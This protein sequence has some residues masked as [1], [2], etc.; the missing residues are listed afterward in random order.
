[1]STPA[2]RLDAA[3][4]DWLAQKGGSVTVRASPRHGCCGGTAHLP[5]AE[6]GAPA[7]PAGWSRREIDGIAVYVDPALT[8]M[9]GVLTIRLEGIARWRRLFVE[10]ATAGEGP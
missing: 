9:S 1:M 4:A 5:V 3:A 2:V 6:V 10:V 7:N 8:G